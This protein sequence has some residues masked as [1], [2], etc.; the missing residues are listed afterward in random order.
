MMSKKKKP[1]V[2]KKL[3]Q[4]LDI[5]EEL[6]DIDEFW[7]NCDDGTILMENDTF[8]SGMIHS[9]DRIA[10]SMKKSYIREKEYIDS[11]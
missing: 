9:M 5:L 4:I 11:N 10:K 8:Y 1:E 3:D 6:S 2:V 7:K